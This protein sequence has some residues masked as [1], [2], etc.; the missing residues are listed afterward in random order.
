MWRKSSLALGF[1]LFLRAV[2]VVAQVPVEYP[3][4]AITPPSS[5]ELVTTACDLPYAV[6]GLGTYDVWIAPIVYGEAVALRSGSHGLMSGSSSK[7][8]SVA[9]K[10]LAVASAVPEPESRSSSP[11][12]F[13]LISLHFV[14]A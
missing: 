12:I 8:K 1:I 2:P 4:M 9:G 7:S 10:S 14:Y 5:C 3:I 13:S 11:T 6:D